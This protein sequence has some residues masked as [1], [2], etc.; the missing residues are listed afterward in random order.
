MRSPKGLLMGDAYQQLAEDE[1]TLFYNP[2]LLGRH[3]GLT[4]SILNINVE[5]TN[6]LKEKDRF[7][8]FP[9]NDPVEITDR[10]VGLPLYFRLG[11]APGIKMQHF[12]INVFAVASSTISL[13]NSTRPILDINYQYDRGFI[14]G[15]AFSFGRG[16]TRNMKKADYDQSGFGRGMKTNVGFA[17]KHITREGLDRS[18]PVFGATL[19]DEITTNGAKDFY[20]IR[21]SLGF[22]KGKGWGYDLGLDQTFSTSHSQFSWGYTIQN[23]LGIDFDE[24][25]GQYQVPDLEQKMGLG[26][27]F[28]QDLG[29]IGYALTADLRPMDQDLPFMRKLHLGAMIDFPI[30]DLFFGLSEG[31]RS[32][33]AEINIFICKLTVGFYTVETGREVNEIPNERISVH[34]NILNKSF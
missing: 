10:L 30:F 34:A 15:Y 2:A 32:F 14:A 29:F 28:R 11:G 23:I 22:S 27:A 24:Y 20:S 8:D 18:F 7:K 6:A 25:E 19:L 4:L 33:G 9:E 17:V 26:T 12:G 3:E 21:D 1:Y 31:Y 16:K 13:L 5:G